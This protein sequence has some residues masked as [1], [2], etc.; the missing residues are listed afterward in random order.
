M[1]TE[2][3][4]ILVVSF[5]TS[6]NDSRELAI[7]AIEGAIGQAYPECEIR[8]AF[9][10]QMIIDK[11][12]ERDGLVIDNVAQALERAAADGIRCLAVQPTH[13]M[14]GLEYMDVLEDVQGCRGSFEKLSVGKP[15]LS[16]DS[17]F[18]AVARAVTEDTSRWD[19]G[20]TAIVL[21]GHGTEAASNEVY[22]KMQAVL[23]GNGFTNYFI[24]TVEADPTLED[25]AAALKRSGPYRRVV[26]QPLMVVA[27]DHAN[28]DMAGDE[29]DS[30]KQVLSARGYEVRCV[31]KGL[32]QLEAVRWIYVQHVRAALQI[33]N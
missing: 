28:N 31:L 2:H 23:R 25:I 6:F 5:G 22:E 11:L 3:T 12:R 26:L 33:L 16:E 21:M 18:Q 29:E 1:R 24:G 4:A 13:L 14:D 8:R 17:D 15:L 10:S 32:G 20:E 27:G 7:G 19:D 9:T 30:W